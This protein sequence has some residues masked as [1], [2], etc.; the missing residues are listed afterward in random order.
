VDSFFGLGNGLV[1]IN[2]DV[3]V[4]AQS[5]NMGSWTRRNRERERK[6]VRDMEGSAGEEGGLKN[7]G[8]GKILD[9]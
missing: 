5:C 6:E 3:D 8:V 2:I 4:V 1:G 9:R 7:N